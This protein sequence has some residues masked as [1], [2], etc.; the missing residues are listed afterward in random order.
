[1]P[2]EV[3][4]A[5]HHGYLKRTERILLARLSAAISVDSS[6]LRSDS[7]QERGRDKVQKILHGNVRDPAFGEFRGHI[8]VDLVVQNPPLCSHS[9]T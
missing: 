2:K 1:M 7:G 5:L 4:H 8:Y 6:C 3:D 9:E